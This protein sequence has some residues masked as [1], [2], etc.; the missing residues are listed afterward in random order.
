MTRA[1]ERGLRI[2]GSGSPTLAV[3][4]NP[5]VERAKQV[6]LVGMDSAPQLV[7]LER[8]L[9]ARGIAVVRAE[10]SAGIDEVLRR[11]I[12]ATLVVHGAE[13]A[14]HVLESLIRLQRSSPVVVVADKEDLGSYF[15][16]MNSGALEYFEVSE[17]LETIAR[18]IEWAHR[19]RAS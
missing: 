12:P 14:Q 6:V 13:L 1:G 17:S 11:R 2:A 8:E 5:E 10:S 4:M 16:L 7:G 18:G 9:K 19:T 3:R 15:C